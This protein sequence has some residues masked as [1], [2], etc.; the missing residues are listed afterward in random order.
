MV[1][2]MEVSET[3]PTSSFSVSTRSSQVMMMS[4]HLPRLVRLVHPDVRLSLCSLE[5]SGPPPLGCK[6]R[7]GGH[8][9]S[10]FLSGLCNI[11]LPIPPSSWSIKQLTFPLYSWTRRR[12]RGSSR[13]TFNQMSKWSHIDKVA[14]KTDKLP[15][16]DRLWGSLEAPNKLDFTEVDFV[17]FWDSAM[18]SH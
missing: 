13:Y 16:C 5:P 11:A 15:K 18:M 8:V 6:R 17:Q 4:I 1:S 7:A 3:L 10:L 9:I 2:V 14:R 12:G